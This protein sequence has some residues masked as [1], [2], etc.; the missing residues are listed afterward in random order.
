MSRMTKSWSGGSKTLWVGV[1]LSISLLT[2]ATFA[3]DADT[4]QRLKQLE[5]QNLDLQKKL[6]EQ[7]GLIND[8]AKKLSEVTGKMPAV[9]PPPDE[10][11]KGIGFGQVRLSGE[12]GAGIFHT[13]SKGHY[14]HS[15]F[16]VDEAK[17][18]VEA[19]LWENYV[20]AYAELDLL[21]RE[22]QVTPPPA[23]E[24]FHLGEL[25]VDFEGVSRL[26]NQPGMLGLRVGRID[27]PFGEEYITRDV[28]DNPLI[29]HSLVDIWGIDEGIE[30]YGKMNR[31]DYV[32]AVQNGGH[33]QLADFNGS[34][35]VVGRLGYNP[36]K[37]LRLSGSGM[38]TGDIDVANDHMAELWF[39]NGFAGFSPAL[40]PGA[41]TFQATL[42]EGDAQ[43][44]WKTGHVKGAGG[45]L[46]YSDDAPAPVQSKRDVYY[47]YL[48]GLQKLP[49]A[50]KFYGAVRWSQLFADNGF[51]IV[52][53][54]Q[55]GPYFFNPALL[56]DRMWRISLGAGYQFSEHLNVKLEYSL[57]RRH[58]VAPRSED[59]HLFAAEV[60]FSF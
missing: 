25:Y 21:T 54:G 57:D 18:F 47:Y 29:S 48:E 19:P 38:T 12:G 45:W 35:A 23:D 37:W 5:Q 50:P 10:P 33:G 30:A 39:G 60:A 44:F 46:G 15:D 42:Y 34:K 56:T 20:F 8:L 51:P 11:K 27:V 13:S 28:I 26:W 4:E 41:K 32:V 53:N 9:L 16:R 58:V 6:L 2:G 1:F 52:G 36:T 55:F 3:A 59:T 40:G 49:Q 31:F 7:Q 22:R 24:N 43:V 14:T 17:L